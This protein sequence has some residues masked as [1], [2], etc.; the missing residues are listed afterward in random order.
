MRSRKKNVLL[1][2]LATTSAGLALGGYAVYKAMRSLDSIL[3]ATV[4]GSHEPTQYIYL[5]KA[6]SMDI[7]DMRPWEEETWGSGSEQNFFQ[8]WLDQ[9]VKNLS[10]RLME[11]VSQ[12]RNSFDKLRAARTLVS[13]KFL[14][15]WD[16]QHLGQQCDEHTAALLA[17][18]PNVNPR[19]FLM[20]PLRKECFDQASLLSKF[21]RLLQKLQKTHQHW[22]LNYFIS[23]LFKKSRFNYW[24]KDYEYLSQESVVPLKNDD[25]NVVT[26]CV[27]AL[28]HH[29]SL[30]D[31]NV[32]A[33]I[34]A[35]GLEVLLDACR[36]TPGS[37]ETKLL[38]VKILLKVSS[39]RRY[40]KDIHVTGW[41]RMLVDWSRECDQRLSSP[42]ASA[43]ANLEHSSDSCLFRNEV[44]ILHP[45]FREPVPPKVDVIIVHGLLGSAHSTWRQRNTEI[46]TDLALS[47]ISYCKLAASVSDMPCFQEE[48]DFGDDFEFVL[49]DIPVNESAGRG[50]DSYSIPGSDSKIKNSLC[51]CCS[52]K[53]QC[54]PKDWLPR[55]FRGLRILG[56]DYYSRITEWTDWCP[57]R[58]KFESRLADK[59]KL[60]RKQ[61][62]DCG[63][64]QRPMVWIGHSMGGLIIKHILSQSDDVLS[65]TKFVFFLGTPHFGS[66]IAAVRKYLAPLLPSPETKELELN[67][68]DLLE[69]HRRFSE[70]VA[71][72]DVQVFTFIETKGAKLTVPPLEVNLDCVAP[73]PCDSGTGKIYEIPVGHVDLAKLSTPL[74][75]IYVKVLD[76]IKSA[77]GS[78]DVRAPLPVSFNLNEFLRYF[79]L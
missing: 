13:L 73:T 60:I 77:A 41:L 33:M 50:D 26:L 20:P 27:E 10:W 37:F 14:E 52:M 76:A 29:I 8:N 49:A 66:P 16:Y 2:T 21:Q 38:A 64:G 59:A 62:L 56:V 34:E 22:C 72:F 17:R 23:K 36:F 11:I 30:D 24:C 1:L 67:S 43:L 5:P 19:M 48:D 71:K 45:L 4:A 12:E 42:A 31:A 63:L 44:C 53:S 69:L 57:F 47:G 25:G 7:N 79:Q 18:E 75:F 58:S 70:F 6:T 74:S 78:D 39:D 65:K 40:L 32:E 35:R 9:K 15:D 54:W 55:D 46:S 28:L 68:P 3:D 61:L 51:S